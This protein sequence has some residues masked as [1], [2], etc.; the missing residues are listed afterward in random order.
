MWYGLFVYF[1]II[2]GIFKHIWCLEDGER[3][4]VRAKEA[5]RAEERVGERLKKFDGYAGRFER[6]DENDDCFFF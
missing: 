3:G 6:G 1:A 4:R 2:W 5:E